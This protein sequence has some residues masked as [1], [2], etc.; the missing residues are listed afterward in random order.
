MKILH[1][2]NFDNGSTAIARLKAFKKNGAEVFTLNVVDNFPNKYKLY[3]YY[4]F[5][6]DHVFNNL[7]TE[8]LKISVKHKP[9]IIFIEKGN[10]VY[11]KTLALLKEFL[12]TKLVHYN[13]DDPFG[14]YQKGWSLLLKTI[15]QYDICFVARKCNIN[16]YKKLGAKIIYTFNR[17]FD[18]ELHK[19]IKLSEDD[20]KKFYTP[21]GFIGSY[22]EE[23]A[24]YISFLIENKIPIK[25]Y[26]GGWK[27]NKHWKII[28]NNYIEGKY[29]GLEYVKVINAMDIALHFL[30]RANRDEQ[31]HRTFEIPA[32]GT[33]MLAQYSP[34]HKELFSIDKAAVLFDTKEDLL[35]KVNY[36]LQNNEERKII[37]EKGYNIIR[38]KGFDYEN[39]IKQILI[40][41]QS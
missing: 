40:L 9:D 15:Q 25:V 29:V 10:F 13:P 20:Y 39:I 28:K 22:E 18:P 1:I 34:F 6:F 36:F 27:N 38:E 4:N 32:C 37:A 31:D 16:E 2:S 7:N 14:S 30:R 5:G 26:G 33:F 11:P 12:N 24:E 17:G 19:K 21:V 35:N 8:I 23:R 41:C 3:L